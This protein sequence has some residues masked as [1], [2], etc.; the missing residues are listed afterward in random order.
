MRD[1][2]DDRETRLET[3]PVRPPPP[4]WRGAVS[5]VCASVAEKTRFADP[6]LVARWAQ[7]VGPELARLC[8]PGRI[9][10]GVRNATLEL[11][12]ASGAAAARLQLETETLRRRL[13]QHLGPDRIGQI[14][15]LQSASA[16]PATPGSGLSRFRSDD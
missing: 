2:R 5:K 16:T 1:R 9:L 15:I 7:F 8:A 11:A 3:R 14:R 12:V 10:G 6:Q 4:H 13:N